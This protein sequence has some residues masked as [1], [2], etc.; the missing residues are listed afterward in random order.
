MVKGVGDG[1]WEFF[2]MGVANRKVRVQLNNL[3][4]MAQ[5]KSYM[6]LLFISE[7]I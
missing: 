5:C 2:K 3:I 4:V 7:Q 6:L 1:S